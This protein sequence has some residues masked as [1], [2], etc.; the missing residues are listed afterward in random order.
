LLI[1]ACASPPWGSVY[2]LNVE[3][4]SQDL[5]PGVPLAVVDY[6]AVPEEVDRPQLVVRINQSQ[7][8][9]A[10]AA[11]WSEPLKTQIANMI[12]EDLVQHFRNASV[13]STSETADRP[14]V[15]LALNV[16]LFDWTPG[17]GAVLAIAWSILTPDFKRV[18]N[19]RSVVLQRVEGNS[20]DALVDAQSRALAAVSV[21]MADAIMSAI[22]ESGQFSPKTCNRP[23]FRCEGSP[24]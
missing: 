7:V 9:I 14:T 10:A 12:A 13:S 16:R 23:D 6:V 24:R 3:P 11:R 19:G 17:A 22:K 15:R 8:R 21:D 2:R 5:D 18:L 20:Y 1:G 4:S